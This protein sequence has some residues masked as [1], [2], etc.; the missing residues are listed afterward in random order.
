MSEQGKHFL[1]VLTKIFETIIENEESF[2][3]YDTDVGDGDMGIGATR[4]SKAVLEVLNLLNI[5]ENVFDS[6]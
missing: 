1:K 6:A 4:A 3:K 2:T 5:E